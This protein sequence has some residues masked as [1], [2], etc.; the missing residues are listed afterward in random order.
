MWPTLRELAGSVPRLVAP[1]S[2]ARG[3]LASILV[4]G[5]A[6][7]LVRDLRRRTRPR[8]E[9]AIGVAAASIGA[10]AMLNAR[11]YRA[12]SPDLEGLDA[13]VQVRRIQ[14]P[15]AVDTYGSLGADPARSPVPYSAPLQHVGALY[16]VGL[17]G[18]VPG[19]FV[20]APSIHA[21]R[22]R[23]NAAATRWRDRIAASSARRKCRADSGRRSP[24]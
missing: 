21:F 4:L 2:G 6:A 22:T 8:A 20:G 3:A 24:G 19:L 23:R 15:I 17:G 14:L 7:L 13:P 1:G 11:L 16:A 18:V 12:F 9:T 10:T 5:S